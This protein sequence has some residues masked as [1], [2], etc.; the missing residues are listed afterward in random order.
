[1]S[2]L[3]KTVV[4]FLALAA[5]L[6]VSAASNSSAHFHLNSSSSRCDLCLTAHISVVE[7]PSVHLFRGPDL[8]T[9]APLLIPFFAYQAL[10]TRPSFSRGPPS[11]S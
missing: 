4:L 11:L 6:G 10:V 5:M 8:E 2:R 9:R 1:M 3:T 7:T